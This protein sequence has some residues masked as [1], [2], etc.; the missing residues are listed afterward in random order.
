MSTWLHKFTTVNGGTIIHFYD[1]TE[2]GSSYTLCITVEYT[3][4]LTLIIIS[5]SLLMQ[6]I[7]LHRQEQILHCSVY[8]Y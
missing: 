4:K 3:K 8:K 2:W 7:H 6:C 1:K 5:M